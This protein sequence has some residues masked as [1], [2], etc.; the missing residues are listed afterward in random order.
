MGIPAADKSP[1]P[2]VS[3]PTTTT[4]TQP[5]TEDVEVAVESDIEGSINPF[6]PQEASGP[7]ADVPDVEEGSDAATD[8]EVEG[9]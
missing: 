4:A 7:P 6:P 1:V 8:S 5:S 2:A 3:S 9:T